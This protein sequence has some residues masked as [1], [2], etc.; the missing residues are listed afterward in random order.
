MIIII[1]LI[2]LVAIVAL[3]TENHIPTC[4]SLH[5]VDADEFVKGAYANH[6]KLTRTASSCSYILGYRLVKYVKD[7]KQD[8]HKG[9]T[10]LV[11][12]NTET[13]AEILAL[14]FK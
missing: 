12:Y 4:V 2:I 13:H 10:Y 8:T 1:S 7:M 3:V 14:G 5:N 11:F 9:K 6:N